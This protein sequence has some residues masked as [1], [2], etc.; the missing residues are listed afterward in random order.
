MREGI[1]VA[2][3]SVPVAGHLF[4]V[5][6]RMEGAKQIERLEET[7]FD[8]HDSLRR[9][10][11]SIIKIEAR[12]DQLGGP[13]RDLLAFQEHSEFMMLPRLLYEDPNFKDFWINPSH[14]GGT[15][16]ALAVAKPR[17]GQF[18]FMMS[19]MMGEQWVYHIPAQTFGLMLQN[20]AMRGENEQRVMGRDPASGTNWVTGETGLVVPAEKAPIVPSRPVIQVS[21]AEETSSS[22]TPTMAPRRK[23]ERVGSLP[24][25]SSGGLPPGHRIESIASGVKFY[26]R[27]IPPIEGKGEAFQIMETQVTQA[28][29]EA[30]MGTNPSKFKGKPNSPQRPVETVSWEDGIK[31]ANALSEKMGLRPAYRGDDNDA[32]LIE[33]ANGFRLP[34]EAEWEWAAKGGEDHEYAGSDKLDEVGW[35]GNNSDRE[36]HPVGQLKANGYGCH[37]FSGNVYEWC[38]DDHGNPG[39]HRPG[40]AER[41][42]RGGSW[43]FVADHC[44]VSYRDRDSPGFRVSALGLRFS[45]SLD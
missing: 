15:R 31:F 44:R 34:F 30:V 24:R 5:V 38:A 39:Q 45:R 25:Q 42:V 21:T 8:Q 7:V 16:E 11:E 43:L 18:S 32:E 36:T 26:E 4:D 17:Q 10:H 28:L 6:H 14:F 23:L 29:Y 35:Y 22:L 13:I 3:E 27:V 33:G 41:V 37:D 1:A 12:F 40:A 2:L 19:D 9:L 20:Q